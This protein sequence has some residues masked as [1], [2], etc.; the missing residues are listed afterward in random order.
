[1]KRRPADTNK[2]PKSHAKT[3][4]QET[5]PRISA[6]RVGAVLSL[7]RRY[8]QAE[9]HAHSAIWRHS[10]I[11]GPG[12]SYSDADDTFKR[13]CSELDERERR[14]KRIHR[15]YVNCWCRECGRM[16]SRPCHHVEAVVTS[17]GTHLS[18][19]H[20]P[21]SRRMPTKRHAPPNLATRVRP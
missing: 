11:A 9:R 21:P 16:N 4:D 2:N 8:S 20:A 17:R 12:D 10:E 14:E 19:L 15:Q 1:M 6:R 3:L 18:A 13:S 7:M 5:S